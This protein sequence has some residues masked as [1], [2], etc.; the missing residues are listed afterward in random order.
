MNEIIQ[1][2]TKISNGTI[3]HAVNCQGTW[4]S[5]LAASL[6][7]EFPQAFLQYRQVYLKNEKRKWNLI[8]KID[9]YKNSNINVV[10]CFTQYDVGV[11]SR[12]TEYSAVK[13]CFREISIINESVLY[14]P[15]YIPYKMCCGLGGS[16]WNIVS[17][18]INTYLPNAIICKEK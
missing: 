14:Q 18:I 3:V 7:N 5:G 12:K 16:D 9:V 17:E 11:T 8:G 4:G 6:K 13:Q 1:D 10:S 2:I 15:V